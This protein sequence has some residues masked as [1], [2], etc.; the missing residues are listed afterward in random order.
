MPASSLYC[1]QRSVS[2]IS[3]AERKRRIASSPFL[4]VP[5]ARATGRPANK[6]APTAPAPAPTRNE[7]RLASP[8][9]PAAAPSSRC[10]LDDSSDLTLM[11]ASDL[12]LCETRAVASTPADPLSGGSLAPSCARAHLAR[13]VRSL[14]VV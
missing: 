9:S 7:R 2:R 6:L 3:A 1:C 11:S 12:L 10:A 5:L 8:P 14:I 13:A 4:S